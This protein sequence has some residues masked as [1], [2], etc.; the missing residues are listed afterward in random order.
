MKHSLYLIA[1]LDEKRGIGKNGMLPWRLPADLAFFQR[2]T[3]HTEDPIKENMVI[4]GRTTW[5]SIPEKH[6]PLPG[7]HNVVLSRREGCKVEGATVHRSLQEALH[8]VDEKIGTVFVIGGG[9]LFAEAIERPDI[10]GLYL[11]EVEGDFGCDTFFPE[12]PARFQKTESFGAE[13]E[14]GTQFTFWRYDSIID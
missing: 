2:T 3:E 5:E 6:R 4:M 12:I 10:T 1:A 8:S 13:E 9:Q 11:T 14:N 7:R